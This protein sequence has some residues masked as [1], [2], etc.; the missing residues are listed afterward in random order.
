ML[1]NWPESRT[2]IISSQGT[3]VGPQRGKHWRHCLCW[4][5]RA[6]HYKDYFIRVF[7]EIV[8]R[9]VCQKSVFISRKSSVECLKWGVCWMPHTDDSGSSSRKLESSCAKGEMVGIAIFDPEVWRSHCTHS[10]QYQ[11]RV[12]CLISIYSWMLLGSAA[13]SK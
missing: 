6:R 8:H 11:N 1:K 5:C 3:A 4:L 12:C 13:D 2:E 10:F 9:N 7:P